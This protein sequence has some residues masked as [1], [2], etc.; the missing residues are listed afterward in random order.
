MN[1]EGSNR[2]GPRRNMGI[3]RANSG[4]LCRGVRVVMSRGSEEIEISRGQEGQWKNVRLPCERRNLGSGI[5]KL[6]LIW[7]FGQ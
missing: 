7:G 4:N 6:I 5:L 3:R 2:L 1:F